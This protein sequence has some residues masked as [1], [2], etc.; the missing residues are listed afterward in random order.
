MYQ[1]ISLS[2]VLPNPV[3]VFMA[4]IIECLISSKTVPLYL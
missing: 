3:V 2:K 4:S 1:Y